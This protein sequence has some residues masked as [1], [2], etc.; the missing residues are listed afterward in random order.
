MDLKLFLKR[1][2]KNKYSGLPPLKVNETYVLRVRGC[3]EPSQRKRYVNN[4]G[5]IFD[6]SWSKYFSMILVRRRK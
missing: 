3:K 5:E 2:T 1:I 6:V 4:R